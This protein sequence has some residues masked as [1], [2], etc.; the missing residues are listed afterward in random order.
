MSHPPLI[1]IGASGLIGS[2]LVEIARVQGRKVVSISHE[3]RA[4]LDERT[5]EATAGA[6]ADIV[7]AAGL[8]DPKLPETALREAN[9]E[10]PCRIFT[11]LASTPGTRFVTLG[12]VME[13]FDQACASNAYLRSKRELARWIESHSEARARHLRLHTVYGGPAAHLK[14]HMFLGMIITALDQR[15]PFS[16]SSGEQLREYHHVEDIA[17]SILRFLDETQIW[18]TGAPFAH[19]LSSGQPVRLSDLAQSIF[20]A[21]GT[22][23]QLKIGAIAA[24]PGENRE[25]RFTPSPPAI[26]GDSRAALP[27]VVTWIRNLLAA[28]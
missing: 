3:P 6:P 14:P 9:V 5:W 22:T 24:A 12:S 17:R 25:Q 26:L 27:G 21:L 10:L 28:R 4:S 8:V 11:R 1:V 20:D 16:M 13:H 7:I 23:G 2:T 18:A 15:T 19:D